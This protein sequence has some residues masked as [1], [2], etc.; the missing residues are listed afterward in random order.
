MKKI[1][2]KTLILNSIS[3]IFSTLYIVLGCLPNGIRMDFFGGF[4]E[5][6]PYFS[7][8]PYGYG[9][10]FPL[11]IEILAIVNIILLAI[12]IFVSKKGLQ[13]TKIV[14]TSIILLFNLV[15]F[16]FTTT[17][18]AINIAMFDIAFAHLAYEVVVVIVKKHNKKYPSCPELGKHP[19][20]K[21][22][23]DANGLDSSDSEAPK[24]SVEDMTDED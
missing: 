23:C 17:P 4:V 16:F 2:K 5:Y 7:A 18:T 24:F 8:M 1:D 14:L 22:F 9:D 13:I 10:I 19:T 11:Y 3:I 12:S 21:E 6:Y 15:E 20:Y